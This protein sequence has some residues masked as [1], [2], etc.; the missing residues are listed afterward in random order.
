MDTGR[1]HR[2]GNRTSTT[3]QPLHPPTIR[4]D[5]DLT[6]LLGELRVLLPTAQLFS[7]FLV[8]VPFAPGF[9][10][11]ATGERHVFLATFGFAIVALVLLS[12][13][14]VQHR[15]LRQLQHRA[16][17]KTFATREIVAGATSL[18]IS[19]VLATQLVLTA[20]FGHRVGSAAAAIAGLLVV[21]AWFALPLVWRRRGHF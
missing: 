15:L 1:D 8:T 10:A 21:L 11:I 16:R 12:A 17:F 13:P 2:S 6:D 3:A 4:D 9:A 7:A 20:V 5:G 19:L 18:A 14:A